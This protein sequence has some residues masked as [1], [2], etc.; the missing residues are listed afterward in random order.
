MHQAK[1]RVLRQWQIQGTEK[2]AIGREERR[3]HT[4]RKKKKLLREGR[5]DEV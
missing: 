4:F 5:T 2:K 1:V 3:E